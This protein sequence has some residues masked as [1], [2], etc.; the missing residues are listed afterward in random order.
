VLFTRKSAV[1][2]RQIPKLHL[3]EAP[4]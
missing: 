4:G 1:A 2:T 3:G